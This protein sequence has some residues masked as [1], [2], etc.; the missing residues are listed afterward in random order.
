[1]RHLHSFTTTRTSPLIV[2][3]H[4]TFEHSHSFTDTLSPCSALASDTLRYLSLTYMDASESSL[5]YSST[6]HSLPTLQT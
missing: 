1:M 5:P 3:S 2:W 6:A 4:P